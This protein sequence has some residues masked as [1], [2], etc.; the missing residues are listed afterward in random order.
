MENSLEKKIFLIC[1]VRGINE[2]E[3]QFLQDYLSDLESKGHKVHYPP[4]DTNQNDPIGLNICSENRAA[5]RNA[6]EIHIY[7][8]SKSE[9]SKFDFGMLF[10]AEKPLIL[11]NKDKIKR[12]P[13]KS[14]ENVLLELDAKYKQ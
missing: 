12:T 10:M 11:I 4:R 9:G 8:T 1:P 14:F 2:E 7:Y 13:H 6:D 3:A 5:I